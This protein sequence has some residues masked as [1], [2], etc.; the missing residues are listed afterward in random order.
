M[1]DQYLCL[2]QPENPTDLGGKI[3]EMMGM[4]LA[5]KWTAPGTTGQRATDPQP[6]V[7]GDQ[8]AVEAEV[9]GPSE[10]GQK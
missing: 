4:A 9:V 1:S 3:Y 5:G 2:L 7:S 6:G 8:E 10:A